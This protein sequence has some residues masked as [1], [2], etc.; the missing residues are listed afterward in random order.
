MDYKRAL[1][2]FSYVVPNMLAG[3]ARPGQVNP[4]REDLSFLRAQGIKAIL[5]LSESPLEMNPLHETDFSYHHVPVDDFTAP[6]IEQVEECMDFVERMLEREKKPV[7]IHCGAG[8][9][10][11]GTM[12]ACYFVKQ[13]RT[14]EEAIAGLRTV[15]PC[16]IET[17]GQKALV[18][19]YEEYLKYRPST[20]QQ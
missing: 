6:T 14:A 4:L 8:C 20:S 15:R 13:G 16:S 1:L 12:L 2:N 3:M 19:Q 7:A 11:T 17:E 9:G 18:Y 10:R 5:S